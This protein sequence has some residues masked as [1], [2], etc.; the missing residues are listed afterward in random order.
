MKLADLPELATP[1]EVAQ[2]LRCSKR[3]VQQ[4]AARGGIRAMFVAGK[5]L[6]PPDA[7]REYLDG[8]VVKCQSAMPAPGSNGAKNGKPGKSSGSTEA[9]VAGNP[10]VP[11]IVQSL[12]S[13][14]RNTSPHLSPSAPV[15]PHYPAHC[16][17]ADRLRH[18]TRRTR[19]RQGDAGLQHQSPMALLVAPNRPCREGKHL[20]GLCAAS[21]KDWRVRE[22][23]RPRAVRLGRRSPP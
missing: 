18:R 11:P 2:V 3:T 7:V 8:Q 19:R 20:P 13:S 15:I 5:Y 1:A 17:R 23:R 6:I 4:L 21:C 12:I 22:Y 14:S 9:S 16:G 10:Q